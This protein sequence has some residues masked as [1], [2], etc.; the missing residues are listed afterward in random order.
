MI[1]LYY[2]I[3]YN[4][5]SNPTANSAT[6]VELQLTTFEY[7]WQCFFFKFY[8]PPTQKF[9]TLYSF[10]LGRTPKQQARKCHKNE[11]CHSI[12]LRITKN[13]QA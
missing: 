1:P 9:S 3:M 12:S 6:Q 11:Y 13:Q 8:I 7:Y 5:N 10:S 2:E 4:G